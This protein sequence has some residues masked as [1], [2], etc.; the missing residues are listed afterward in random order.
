MY[1]ASERESMTAT[2]ERASGRAPQNGVDA[3]DDWVSGYARRHPTASL[4]TVGDQFIL[5][6]RT[7]QYLFVDL[8]T[9]QFQWREF[10]RQ[11]AFM[12]G[13]AVVPTVLVALPIGDLSGGCGERTRGDPAGGLAYCRDPDGCGGGVGDHRGPGF[14]HDA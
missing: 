10:V 5:G 12:A 14:T 2:H 13:T 11:G 1:P 6:L 7:V 3:I 4:A 9:G 8:V